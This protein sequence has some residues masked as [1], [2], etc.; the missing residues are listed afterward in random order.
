MTGFIISLLIGLSALGALFFVRESSTPTL[1]GDLLTGFSP[2]E[3]VPTLALRGLAGDDETALGYQALQAGELATAHANLLFDTTA[4]GSSRAGLWAAL[5]RA[6]RAAEDPASATQVARG[7][8]P[9]ALTDPAVPSLERA[10]MLVQTAETYAEAG[11]PD[12]SLDSVNQGRRLAEQMPDLL[13][14]QRSE[15]FSSLAEVAATLD[16]TAAAD[17]LN[18]LARNP[19]LTPAGV[20]ITPRLATLTAPPPPDDTLRDAVAAREQAAAALADR[21]AFSGGVDIGPEREALANA[22]RWEDQ[23]RNEYFLRM[24]ATEMT[25]NERLSILLDHRQWQARKLRIALGGYGI[26]LIP[27]WEGNADAIRRDLSSMISFI[28]PVLDELANVQDPAQVQAEV[29][30]EGLH[31]QALQYDL[32]LFSDGD[33]FALSQRIRDRENAFATFGTPVALPVTFDAAGA[34]P[35]FR[36]MQP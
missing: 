36:V 5:M 3:V 1:D 33:P 12:A 23:V 24:Q 25:L 10:R 21:I 8:A 20:L 9:L 22:L 11:L 31:W 15:I 13:P 19:F 14:V 17:E 27:E 35:G 18:E 4:A 2:A 28:D 7:T 16:A 26:S 6:Y 30:V 32:G 29:K 34:P